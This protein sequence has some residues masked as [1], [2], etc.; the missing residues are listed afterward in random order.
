[1][2]EPVVLITG[3]AGNIGRVVTRAVLAAGARVAVPVYK[4]DRPDI[5]DPIK[6]EFGD[7]LLV[8]ALDL[9]TERGADEAVKEV[10]EWAGRLDALV[11]LVGGYAGGMRVD[12]T[13]VEVYDRMMD[14]NVK[15]AF[16]V[17][18]AALRSMVPGGGSVVFVSSRAATG[19]GAGHAVYAA[20]K[21]AL[22][23]F[24]G[25]M[26]EEYRADGVR[27]NVLLPSTVD[28]EANRAAM[29][30]ADYAA[31]TRPET[32]AERIVALLTDGVTGE[33]IEV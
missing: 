32:I 27:V 17:G 25:A 31:W 2:S 26:A 16:L 30:G 9:T 15:S 8:F 19:D 22:L 29:P 14:L 21:S 6:R 28:T 5:L 7:R 10:V 33:R 11:H 23:T 3:G 1:M 13:P 4:T 24:A 20:A 18:R 12:A